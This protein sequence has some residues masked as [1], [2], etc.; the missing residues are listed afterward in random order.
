MTTLAMQND[1]ISIVRTVAHAPS[2][3]TTNIFYWWPALVLEDWS[4]VDQLCAGVAVVPDFIDRVHPS[5]N[6]GIFFI[7]VLVLLV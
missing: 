3:T 2:D 4:R 7:A 5:N 1:D 6:P